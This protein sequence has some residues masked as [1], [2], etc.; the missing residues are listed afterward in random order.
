MSH[1]ILRIACLI[2]FIDILMIEHAVV[3]NGVFKSYSYKIGKTQTT[4]NTFWHCSH[5]TF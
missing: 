5:S 1:G 2:T 3:N 4:I